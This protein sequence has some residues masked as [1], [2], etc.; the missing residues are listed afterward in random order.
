MRKMRFQKGKWSWQTQGLRFRFLMPKPIFFL[1]WWRKALQELFLGWV[2][3]H[4][5]CVETCDLTYLVDSLH[6][7]SI[8]PSTVLT[9][10]PN[11]GSMAEEAACTCSQVGRSCAVVS[12]EEEEVPIARAVVEEEKGIWGPWLSWEGTSQ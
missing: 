9:L 12:R 1:S 5:P 6:C 2:E 11:K 7:P 10:W 3:P 4:Q 8:F